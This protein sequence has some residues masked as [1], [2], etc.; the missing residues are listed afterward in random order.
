[1]KLVGSELEFETVLLDGTVFNVKDHRG[2]VV[3]INFWGTTC[4]PCLRE[5]PAMK[6]LY[7]KYHDRGYE[8]VAACHD[9]ESDLTAF[10]AKNPFPWS[11]SRIEESKKRGLRDYYAYYGIFGI[12]TTFLVDRDG[13]VR[14]TQVGADDDALEREV[15]KLFA[16]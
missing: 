1:M 2:K 10:L 3:L 16:E 8:M 7:E 4:G 11:F 9:S 12:P 14:Y 6:A 13:I 5:F 15:G